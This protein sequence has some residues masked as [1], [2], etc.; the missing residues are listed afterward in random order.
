MQFQKFLSRRKVSSK[1]ASSTTHICIWVVSQKDRRHEFD[2]QISE[3]R[4][5][6]RA[7]WKSAYD[8]SHAGASPTDNLVRLSQ[9]EV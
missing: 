9:G 7:A 1:C 4:S 5:D 3:Q 8:I 2:T 6:E